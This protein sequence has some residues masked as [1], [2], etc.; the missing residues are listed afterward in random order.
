MAQIIG[1]QRGPDYAYI[2]NGV[3]TN[4]VKMVKLSRSN[5][6]SKVNSPDITA[7]NYQLFIAM[8]NWDASISRT[9]KVPV[10][11]TNSVSK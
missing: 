4:S 10:V 3:S 7:T 6:V 8:T 11:K 1:N 9:N 5:M 2:T